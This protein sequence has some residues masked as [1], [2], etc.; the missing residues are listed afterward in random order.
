M[1]GAS[2]GVNYQ[3]DSFSKHFS[4]VDFILDCVGGSYWKENMKVLAQDGK[5]ILYGL[6][7]GVKVDGPLLGMMLAKLGFQNF[8][9]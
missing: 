9:L 4:N 7:G 5:I 3:T 1:L 2:E 8:R 6:L